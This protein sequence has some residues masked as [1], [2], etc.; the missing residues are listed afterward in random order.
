MRF[1]SIGWTLGLVLSAGTALGAD[2][3]G[4]RV[5]EGPIATKSSKDPVTVARSALAAALP[6]SSA[7]ELVLTLSTKLHAT[8]RVVRFRQEHHGVPVAFRGAGVVLR[9]DGNAAWA[10]TR[11]ESALPDTTPTLSADAAAAL[12]TKWSGLVAHADDARLAIV[13]LPSGA[14]LTWV[15][16]PRERIVELAYAPVVLVDAQSGERL[17][18]WNA[19]V[20][21][22]AAQVFPTNPTASP[23]PTDVTLPLPSGATTL[24]NAVVKSLNCIDQKQT[25]KVSL[26]GFTLTVHVCGLEQTATADTNG[27]FLYPPGADT[28]P[29]DAFSEV[30]MFY[31]V[32]RAYERFQGFGMSDLGT[33]PLPT[34]SNLRL[35]AGYQTQDLAKMSDPNQ[36]LVPFQNAF[37]S[38]ADPLFSSVFGLNGAAMWFG[39][40][41]LRDYSYDG[42]V[43]YHE[44]THAVVDH[45]LALVGSWHADDQGLVDSPGAMNE[46]LADF[47]SSTIAGDPKVGEYAAQDLAPGLPAI[48]DLSNDYTC[49]ANISGEVHSDS[50]FWSA[51]LWT[52]RANLAANEAAAFDQ[53]IFDVMAAAPGGDLGF[54]DLASLF[55]TSVKTE[56]GQAVSDPL[57]AELQTRGTLPSCQRMREYAGKPLSGSDPFLANAFIAP[58]TDDALA[59]GIPYAPGVV[60]FHVPVPAALTMT[61]TFTQVDTGGGG[62]PFQTGT[63]FAPQILVRWGAAP[64][65]FD[66]SAGVTSNADLTVDAPITSG[67]GAATVDVPAGADGAYVMIVNTGSL[68]GGYKNVDFAFSGTP[69]TAPDA[70]DDAGADAGADAGPGKQPAA[71]D[72]GGGCGCRTSSAPTPAFPAGLALLALGALVRRRRR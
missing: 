30:S 43:V 10:V 63:P 5:F 4:Q 38:P 72:S 50:Q 23:T 11:L 61:V 8:T 45:T 21:A 16:Y 28:D 47:F 69:V 39:Q 2:G 31:H 55:V 71:D 6:S 41:P 1:S 26:Y 24:E 42:D 19:A 3:T 12:A 53:A 33:K 34:I 46:G 9:G 60:A 29:E 64:I 48:R 14:R 54:D 7:L 18:G 62:N 36:P 17:G 13:P 66:W 25:K 15:V 58:G 70:G 59:K 49:P 20:H 27:D 32:N 44:F 40:G 67:H 56:L 22:G 51:G 65:S 35:P 52:A 57:A 37:F 68:E